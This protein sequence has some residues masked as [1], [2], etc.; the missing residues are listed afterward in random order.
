MS[1]DRRP[2]SPISLPITAWSRPLHISHSDKTGDSSTIRI[3][4]QFFCMV[5]VSLSDLRYGAEST[6]TLRPLWTGGKALLNSL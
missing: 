5:Q 6:S 1:P 2:L 4:N 3:A